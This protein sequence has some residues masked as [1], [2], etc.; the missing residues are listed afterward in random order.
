MKDRKQDE[1]IGDGATIEGII[2]IERGDMVT[3]HTHF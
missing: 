3:S 1:I 2:M